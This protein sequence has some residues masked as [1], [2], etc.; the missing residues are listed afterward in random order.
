MTSDGVR[1]RYAPSPTGEPHVGNIRTAIFNWLFAR[2]HGGSFVIRVEDTDQ[3]RKVEGATE[4]LLDALR[5]LGIDWDEGPEVGGEFGPY[6]QSQRLDLYQDVSRELV[7]KGA[8][9]PCYCST[10]R[11]AEMRKEQS[12]RK[13]H[14]G[15]DGTCRSL[16]DGERRQR[17]ADGSNRVVRFKMPAEDSISFTDLVR[18][19]VTFE[20]RLIDDFVMLKS[21]GFPTYHLANV[22]DDH[23]M[24][25]SH[26]LRAEEWLPSTPRHL[27][28]Y[29]ALGWEPPQFAHLPIILAPD[30]SKL[31][32][33]HGATSIMEFRE[34]GYLPS[35]V[36]NFLTLL[37]WS[38]DDKTEIFSTEELVRDFSIEQV[39]KAGAIFNLDKLNWMNGYYLREMSHQ[40]LADALLEYWHQYPPEEI[41]EPPEAERARLIAALVQE[42]LKTLAD[43][44]PLVRFLFRDP[45]Y[46]PA[47]LVQKGMDTDG[48]RRALEASLASLSDLSAFDGDAIEGLLRPMAQELGL[49]A[50]QLFGSLRIATTG[51]VIA[52]PLFESM[53]LLGR[54]R[55][56][57]SIAAAVERL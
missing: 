41:L 8:A 36:E 57:A 20:N 16:S 29:R 12:R 52:P 3:A 25:I 10:E 18:G 24:R 7:T 45:V 56:L 51:Q 53:E 2:H 17:E 39:G 50:G 47:D 14:S 4:E 55:S 23:H 26:V 32:K 48:T 9:Y 31:S 44:A 37:G 46:E 15:Y 13:E 5:W 1:V 35:A 54:D 6:Y 42:R 30:R 21:D 28:L 33:R 22:V 11:L 40:Q 19:D 49:K 43:A 27:H 38:F 34:M